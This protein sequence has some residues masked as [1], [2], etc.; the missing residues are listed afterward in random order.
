MLS[1]KLGTK[2]LPHPQAQ[3]LADDR[4]KESRREELGRLGALSSNL[5]ATVD[6]LRATWGKL[7]G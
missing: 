5:R 3:T 4:G 2:R 6:Y 1:G 7:W